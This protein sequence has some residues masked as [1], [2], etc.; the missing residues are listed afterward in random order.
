MV[1]ASV[2]LILG[3]R[4]DRQFGQVVLLGFGGMLA[5]V[6]ADVIFALPPFDEEYAR[7]RL[8]ELELA[9]LLKDTRGRPPANV[10][11]YCAMAAR[12]SAMVDGLRDDLQEVDVKPVI[13][14]VE[15]C[16]AVDALVV[17]RT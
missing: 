3:A 13:F 12:F 1:S 15:H 5:E 16:V 9:P 10:D 8:N 17:A 6:I 4:C 14:G 2:E 11:A 7:R